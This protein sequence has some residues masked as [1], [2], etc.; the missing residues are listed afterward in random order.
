MAGWGLDKVAVALLQGK[1]RRLW[2]FPSRLIPVLVQRL[3]AVRAMSWYLWNMPRYERT[4]EAFGALRI[5]LLSTTISLINGCRYST[6]GHAYA[7]QLVYLHERG[8]LFPMDEHAIAGL[9][10]LEQAQVRDR[11]AAALHGAG[12]DAEVRW[13]DRLV[14]LAARDRLPVDQDDARIAHLIRMFTVLNACGIAADVQP[15][16]AHDPLNKDEA[17]KQ[18]YLLLR[19]SSAA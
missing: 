5:H 4:L 11:L 15:D 18:R 9:Q 13:I 14:A 10:G 3:G 7:L 16:E 17:L 2:G 19:A 8:E 12:L 6:F 1:P